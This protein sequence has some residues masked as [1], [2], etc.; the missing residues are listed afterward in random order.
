MARR[1]EVFSTR[2][3]KFKDR[4]FLCHRILGLMFIYF[5]VRFVFFQ[6]GRGEGREIVL[7]DFGTTFFTRQCVLVLAWESRKITIKRISLRLASLTSLFAINLGVITVS[8]L[9][10]P[11]LWDTFMLCNDWKAFWSLRFYLRNIFAFCND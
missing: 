2:I 1:L 3:F 4:I 9:S 5:V 10:S 6:G 8:F 7:I 11:S